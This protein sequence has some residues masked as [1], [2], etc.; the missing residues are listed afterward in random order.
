MS[1]SAVAEYYND[2]S[3]IISKSPST[4]SSRVLTPNSSCAALYK[5][6]S[7]A[8]T[9]LSRDSPFFFSD[10]ASCILANHSG[11]PSVDHRRYPSTLSNDDRLLRNCGQNIGPTNNIQHSNSMVAIDFS[12]LARNSPATVGGLK[13]PNSSNFAQFHMSNAY[14]HP[15]PAYPG[16]GYSNNYLSNYNGTSSLYSTTGTTRSHEEDIYEDL[17]YVTLR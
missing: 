17:C 8:N 11:Q 10:T 6:S 5:S 13:F 15:P 1:S 7:Q 4:A 12:V 9:P 14:H 2:L 16:Q 3:A